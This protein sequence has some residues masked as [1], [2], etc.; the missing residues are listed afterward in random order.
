VLLVGSGRAR[1]QSLTA[2]A[3]F[4]NATP[5][6]RQPGEPL[7]SDVSG[8]LDGGGAYAYLQASNNER[9]LAY[10]N[11][12]LYLVSHASV[13]GSTA[14][15]RVLDALTGADTGGLAATGISGGQF[16]VNA[17]AVGTDGAIYVGNLTLQSTTDPFKVYKWAT[18]GS[19]PVV[20]YSGDAGLPGSRVGDSIAGFGGGAS[21]RIASGFSNSPSVTGNNGYTVVNPTAGTATAISFSTPPAAGE[22]RLGLAFSD[23]N[24]LF[25]KQ[26]ISAGSTT[27]Y[28]TS[29]SGSTGTLVASPALTAGSTVEYGLAYTVLNGVP[30]L[31]ALSTG[32]SHISVYNVADP[33]N[34]VLLANAAGLT[35]LVTNLNQTGQIAWGAATINGDGSATQNLYGLRTNGGIRA[36]TFSLPAPGISGDYNTDSKVDAQD[37]VLWRK[38]PTTYGGDPAGYNAWR[39]NFGTGGPGSG[40]GLAAGA[41]P[42]PN[43]VVLLMT[44]AVI[45]LLGVGRRRS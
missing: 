4:G 7:P 42:E 19:S 24:H 45:S 33:T 34:P 15:V 11:G 22:M 44:S 35:G 10:G 6:W 8:T 5:G 29:Y 26:V 43:T 12:H 3:S 2:L 36:F 31:A 21:T 30:L 28:Y 38:S 25:S 39:A 20:A 27:L 41:V 37:Y 18:E 14:N 32:D 13:S 9:G 40:S 23:A 16:T 17:A 1:A